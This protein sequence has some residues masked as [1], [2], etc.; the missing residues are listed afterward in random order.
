M[1]KWWKK[2]WRLRKQHDVIK[3]LS[4]FFA[5]GIAFLVNAV[6]NGV[7]LYRMSQ[8]HAEYILSGGANGSITDAGMSGI[9]EI[10]GV[11]VLSRQR[12]VSVTFKYHSNEAAFTC[13]MLSEEYIG[14]VY[15]IKES[16][17]TM[18]FYVNQSAYEQLKQG[19]N[20][21]QVSEHD[22]AEHSLQVSYSMEAQPTSSMSN[23]DGYAD[24]EAAAL[25]RTA[26]IVLIENNTP[27]LPYV[28]CH[29]TILP[30]DATGIR[31]YFKRQLSEHENAGKLQELGFAIENME[32]IQEKDYARNI[33]ADRIGHSMV[34]A[35]ICLACTAALWKYGYANITA[36][37]LHA[38]AMDT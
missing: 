36:S 38:T 34:A 3:V 21:T 6:Y 29:G 8:C 14:E 13:A 22:L 2:F 12:D 16:G 35:L 26:K 28:C 1:M 5:L 17:A 31:V 20:G 11:T 33:T 10:E 9:Q 32:M 24:T 37:M 4:F 19:L 30:G 27:D 18:T 15:G 7:V 23:Q 25:W